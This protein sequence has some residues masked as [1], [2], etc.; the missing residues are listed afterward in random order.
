MRG[1]RNRLV[2]LV[3]LSLRARDEKEMAT[4]GK[5]GHKRCRDDDSGGD[6]EKISP[7]P[8]HTEVQTEEENRAVGIGKMSPQLGR[9]NALLTKRKTVTSRVSVWGYGKIGHVSR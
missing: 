2:S 8:P 3:H 5:S 6:V 4:R 7:S 1:D 9:H